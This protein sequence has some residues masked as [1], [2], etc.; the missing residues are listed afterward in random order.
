MA[1]LA[2]K[3]AGARHEAGLTQA[4]LGDKLGVTGDAVRQWEAGTA[5][6]RMHRLRALA[7]ALGRTVSYF[8]DDGPVAGAAESS[9]PDLAVEAR[10]LRERLEQLEHAATGGNGQSSV[11]VD[12]LRQ[13]GLNLSP[14]EVRWLQT[15]EGAPCDTLDKAVDLVLL[16]RGWQLRD[17]LKAIGDG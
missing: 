17:R 4:E 6:P 9:P 5:K 15:Y 10:L 1:T 11:P 12:D 8:M 3:I 2:R 13:R 7:D 16:W 14:D